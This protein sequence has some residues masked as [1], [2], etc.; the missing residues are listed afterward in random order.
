MKTI[1]ISECKVI[2][3]K[4]TQMGFKKVGV[5]L[6]YELDNLVIQGDILQIQSHRYFTWVLIEKYSG[7]ILCHYIHGA[8]QEN[9][10]T[11]VK[12]IIKE[13]KREDNE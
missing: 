11:K 3:D 7:Y 5:K 6:E 4:L 2:M 12:K 1:S 13:L 8:S 9:F 10:I